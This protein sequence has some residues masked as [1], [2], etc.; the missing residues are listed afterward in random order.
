VNA[1]SEPE[2]RRTHCEEDYSG[3][4]VSFPVSRASLCKCMNDYNSK[5]R[6]EGVYIV[7]RWE[8]GIDC[9]SK[10]FEDHCS[11]A[12]SRYYAENPDMR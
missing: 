12:R 4:H 6:N 1:V 9:R 11:F 2:P 5:H 3:M 7:V 10:D 8:Q